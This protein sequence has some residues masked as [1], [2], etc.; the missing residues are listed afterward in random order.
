MKTKEK[1]ID[2]HD[3]T[4]TVQKQYDNTPY[5][6]RTQFLRSMGAG[7]LPESWCVGSIPMH[8]LAQWMKEENVDW[9]E[10]TLDPWIVPA[11]IDTITVC[12]G[13]HTAKGIFSFDNVTLIAVSLEEA[14]RIKAE[15]A[16]GSAVT[17]T[18]EISEGVATGIL[19][20]MEVLLVN[21]V[22]YNRHEHKKDSGAE[23]AANDVRATAAKA[24]PSAVA[25]PR[26]PRLHNHAEQRVES[27][28]QGQ[29]EWV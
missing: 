24:C 7:K 23:K 21:G 5:L 25:T 12:I 15:K 10:L 14:G 4:F 13:T 26:G 19:K 22:A 18:K 16:K 1:F 6:E 29:C 2:N 11:N 8:L 3:G 9:T 27:N 20:G 28:Q 17:I